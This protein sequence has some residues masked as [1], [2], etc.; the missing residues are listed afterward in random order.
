MNPVIALSAFAAVFLIIIFII[1]ASRYRKCPSD[2]IM[3]IYGRTGQGAARC[4]HGGATFIWPVIQD[5]GFL[6]LRPMQ[7]N[8]NLT[9]ALS[10]QNIRV[11]VPSV[12]TV[13]VTTDPQIMKN[14]AERLFGQTQEAISELAKDIAFGQLRLVI[15]TLTIE[16][17]NGD[18]ENFLREIEKNVAGELNKIGLHLLNVNITDITDESGYIN[19][20]GKRAAAEAIN[21]AIIAVAE[22]ER[23]GGIGQADAKK[24]QRIK[25][26][27]LETE[28]QTGEANAERDRHV[29]I[30]QAEAQATAGEADAE[31]NR[32]IAVMEANA[33]AATGEA[34]AERDRRI[35]VKLADAAA[36]DG[37]NTSA[38]NIAKSNAHRSEEE[39]EAFR[40]AEA[41]QKVA[42]A[43]IMKAQYEADREA[44]LSRAELEMAKQKA[45][46]IVASEIE[47][48][49]I[50]IAA[51]AEAEKRRREAR[52]E[53]DAIFARFDA[54]ARGNFQVLKAKADGFNAIIG[55]C[56]GDSNAAG[57]ML[58]IEKLEDLVRI[59][60]EAIQNIKIDKV[61]VWE[62]GASQNGKTST[63]NFLSGMVQSLPALHDVAGMAGIDLPKYLG[64]VKNASADSVETVETK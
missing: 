22:E 55:A 64:E 25:V 45:E 36:I 16:E 6:T 47:K 9:G 38:I 31:K 63:A 50:E 18:R 40:R 49:K 51:E 14:A 30:K 26:A 43:M 23:R 15:S 5:Y 54:E 35:A 60:S 32:R 1:Y 27:Y 44:Q 19:A 42:D 39:A 11:N 10:K 8:V 21:S 37:E 57:K 58:V 2:R 28:A 48:Q 29:A 61:T 33:T 24:E 4:I 3:V 59:Q 56:K 62:T 13:A 17:I 7:I 20:I 46:I 41:A 34:N 53:A 52:G 12:F